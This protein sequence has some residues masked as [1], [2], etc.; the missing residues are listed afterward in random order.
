EAHRQ[1]AQHGDVEL[2]ALASRGLHERLERWLAVERH[3]YGDAARA[4]ILGKAS[5]VR[6]DRLIGLLA[7]RSGQRAAFR[8]QVAPQLAAEG[9]CRRRSDAPRLCRHE[10]LL[11]NRSNRWGTPSGLKAFRLDRICTPSP[12][13]FNPKGMI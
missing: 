7:S 1:S 8:A 5:Q 10:P 11:S 4:P 3:E 13:G 2:L 9:V 6:A 12:T